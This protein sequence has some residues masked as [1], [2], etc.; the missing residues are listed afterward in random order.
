MLYRD[1]TDT[2]RCWIVK[3]HFQIKGH[4]H[5]CYAVVGM[6]TREYQFTFLQMLH[7]SRNTDNWATKQIHTVL[8][9]YMQACFLLLVHYAFQC[10]VC[11]VTLLKCPCYASTCPTPRL[12]PSRCSKYSTN[13]MRSTLTRASSNSQLHNRMSWHGQLG[14]SMETHTC[15]TPAV[16][17]VVMPEMGIK[18]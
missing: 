4:I 13:L 5:G 18:Y 3:Q 10:K 8:Q 15:Y 16:P 9:V 11:C 6:Y 12:S 2:I 1:C 7:A 14:S 17:V